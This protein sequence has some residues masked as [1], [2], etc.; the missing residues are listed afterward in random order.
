MSYQLLYLKNQKEAGS[1][2]P[3]SRSYGV[4]YVNFS[5]SECL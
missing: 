3:P 1:A 2:S 5:T 4:K